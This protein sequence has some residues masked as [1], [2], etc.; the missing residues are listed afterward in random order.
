M[1]ITNPHKLDTK[2]FTQSGQQIKCLFSYL[3]KVGEDFEM[4]TPFVMCKDYFNEVIYKEFNPQVT[5]PKIYGFTTNHIDPS[6]KD[7]KYVYFAID[8]G[9]NK[10]IFKERL[11]LYNKVMKEN[12]FSIIKIIYDDKGVQVLRMDKKVMYNPLVASII[13][14]SIRIITNVKTNK[15]DLPLN[16]A[17]NYELGMDSMYPRC[18]SNKQSD[19]C[20]NRFREFIKYNNL[21]GYRKLLADGVEDDIKKG[22]PTFSLHCNTGYYGVWND[23]RFKTITSPFINLFREA[24]K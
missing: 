19:L 24:A 10:Q 11:A 18:L 13:L 21:K 12:K 2:G 20:F 17:K 8:H 23:S 7:S 5:I 3:Y 15:V 6:K 14:A 1:E 9:C 22:H 4:Q 16:L